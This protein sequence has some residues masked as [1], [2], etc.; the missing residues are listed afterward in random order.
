MLRL[1]I[2]AMGLATEE[3]VDL[4]EGDALVLG[5]DPAPDALAAQPGLGERGALRA[6]AHRIAA[7]SVSGSHA[8][9]VVR[10]AEARVLDLQSRNGTWV[11]LPR[12]GSVA[13][14]ASG[15]LTVRL[16]G[17]GGAAA[18]GRAIEPP[19]YERPEELAAGMAS[20]IE[21]WLGH[22]G[23]GARVWVSSPA[24]AGSAGGPSGELT[25]SLATGEQLS[26]VA[27]RTLDE[28]FQEWMVVVARYVA[29]Q[30][31]LYA[32][33]AETRGDGTILA[34]PAI[35]AVH[36]RVVDA[37]VR[38]TTQLVL[39][40]PSGTG[41]ERLASA[42]HRHLGRG[43]PL[44]TVNCATLSRDRLVADLFGA[45][46][47]A[48]TGAQR[49]MVGAVERADGGTLFLDELGEM[50]IEV[51]AQLLR[52]LDTGEYQ[53]LGATGVTR[54][55]NVH[56]VAAT[57]RD[58]RAMVD[59]GEF[60]LDLFFRIAI[61]VVEVPP[62]RERFA[63]AE[64]YLAAQRLGAASALE[65]L[66]PEALEALR[67]HPWQGNFR[68]LINL[69]RRF[70]RPAEAGSIDA[71]AVQRLLGAGGLAAPPPA[72]ASDPELRG[73]VGDWTAWLRASAAAFCTETGSAGPATW[74][75]MTTFIEQYLKPYALVHMAGIA[76][77]PSAE[78]A[79]VARVAEALRADRGT[80]IKQL[81]RFFEARR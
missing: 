73:A 12:G 44:V 48:Y 56:L 46:A 7:P 74:S 20:A 80:V 33:E 26:V 11:R 47:G 39:L 78:A 36:R 28:Q 1:R 8:A 71:A 15:E 42:F 17:R 35:R 53:R 67:R 64:A 57:N 16:G 79:P 23:L 60:R 50:P 51:Q 68:E 19:R 43:G 21:S 13:A 14:P 3:I 40:G 61:E 55:A 69:V 10:G 66:Q 76:H 34:S 52:F 30:N 5:R 4:A 22:H 49:T 27:A 63:D 29:A 77:L 58:L 6:R 38:G 70:P 25:F 18:V 45:E 81:R 31:L 2:E 75:E 24:S 65:A 37:A 41:K 32:A 62:L 59:R 9:V 72:V 54:T